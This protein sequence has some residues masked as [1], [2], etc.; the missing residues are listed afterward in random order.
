MVGNIKNLSDEQLASLFKKGEPDAFDELVHRYYTHIYRFMVR[1]TGQEHLSEDLTQEIF[2]KLYRSID[3]FDEAKRF[4]P[5][6]FTLAANR[7]R[8]ELRSAKRSARKVVVD[9]SRHEEDMSLLNILPAGSATP[10]EQALEKETSEQ[11]REAMMQLSDR[12]REILI[13]A[14]YEKMQYSEIAQ[15]LDIPLGTVK[16]RLH[17]AVSSFGKVWKENEQKTV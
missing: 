12:L 9:N 17:K 15:T 5:W 13:L 10:E 7:A 8:D 4:K 11:V 16:S 14:Y 1:F 3:L 6:F 2:I